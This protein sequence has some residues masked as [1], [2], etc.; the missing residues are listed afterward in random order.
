[1]DEVLRLLPARSRAQRLMRM[2]V[3]HVLEDLAEVDE[4]AMQ[5]ALTFLLV[6]LTRVRNP[7]APA[8]LVNVNTGQALVAT[9]I[10]GR[11]DKWD[12]TLVLEIPVPDEAAQ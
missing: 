10:E 11:P 12:A 6:A 4:D 3:P 8:L 1:M 5:Q 2:V 7:G 9:P